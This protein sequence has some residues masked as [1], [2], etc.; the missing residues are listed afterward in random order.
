VTRDDRATSKHL[1][2]RVVPPPGAELLV[3]RVRGAVRGEIDGHAV[4]AHAGTV[5]FRYSAP[6][7]AGFAMK[8]DLD[9]SPLSIAI[10]AQRPGFPSALASVIGSRPDTMMAKPGMLPP[11][12]EM[13]ESD[14]TVT[15]QHV[16]P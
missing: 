6:P 2:L 15:V 13:Q 5:G 10:A 8:L 3:V 7:R 11:W 1:E 16:S 12:D 14:A 9:A 4:P